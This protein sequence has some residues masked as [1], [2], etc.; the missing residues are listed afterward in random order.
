MPTMNNVSSTVLDR[1]LDPFVECLSPGAA[2]ALTKFRFSPDLRE[3]LASLAEKCNLGK[4]SPKEKCE[5]EA[6]VRAIDL[7]ALLQSKAR[8]FL[9]SHRKQ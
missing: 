7:V 5:Y 1:V 2:R 4:L 6:Y 8:R 9:K 3:R